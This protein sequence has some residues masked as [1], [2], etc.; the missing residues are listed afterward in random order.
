MFTVWSYW[1]L[2]WLT[3]RVKTYSLNGFCPN[4]YLRKHVTVCSYRYSQFCFAQPFYFQSSYKH[5]LTLSD[6]VYFLYY[7]QRRGSSHSRQHWSDLLE[8]N[9]LITG[10]ERRRNTVWCR[11]GW[12]RGLGLRKPLRQIEGIN[13]CC[14]A[15]GPCGP[16]LFPGTIWLR[17]GFLS[18]SF[19]DVWSGGSVAAW[20]TWCFFS[21]PLRLYQ[22]S[23]SLLSES[24][25]TTCTTICGLDGPKRW[26]IQM[27]N[28][29]IFDLC[30][31]HRKYTRIHKKQCCLAYF[32][33]FSSDNLSNRST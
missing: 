21:T 8:M 10:S 32:L 12:N 19:S 4:I 27:L 31:I 33:L 26:E 30:K 20:S 7:C 2:K 23:K 11:G 14:P 13:D 28:T 5:R 18:C 17:N 9:G 29:D 1:V 15:R 25:K 3:L 22:V 16:A 6:M 24:T